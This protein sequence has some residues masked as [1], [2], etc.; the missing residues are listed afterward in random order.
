MRTTTLAELAEQG[1]AEEPL[2][3][4]DE[5][6]QEEPRSLTVRKQDLRPASKP[7]RE[8]KHEQRAKRPP[9]GEGDLDF[10]ARRGA[11][12]RSV[13][14]V[15]AGLSRSLNHARCAEEEDG[16]SLRDANDDGMTMV[17]LSAHPRDPYAGSK[18]GR[19]CGGGRVRADGRWE[20][21]DATKLAYASSR[22]NDIP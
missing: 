6:T 16:L 4:T 7:R 1:D 22:F 18:T 17:A 10:C 20:S 5:Y 3:L 14:G 12:A 2:A 21:G 9:P 11:P 13:P 8:P 15:R 19:L